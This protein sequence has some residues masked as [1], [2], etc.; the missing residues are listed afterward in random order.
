MLF[1]P[2][3][4]QVS[5]GATPGSNES[6]ISGSTAKTASSVTPSEIA[7]TNIVEKKKKKRRKSKPQHSVDDEISP[8]R[9]KKERSKKKLSTTSRASTN[10]TVDEPTS[11]TC[12][13]PSVWKSLKFRRKT[14]AGSLHKPIC[15]TGVDGFVAAWIVSELLVRGYK[16]RGTVQNKNDDI[17]RLYELPHA[18]KNLTIVETSLL[19]AQSCDM[20]VDGCDFVIHSGTPT[21]CSVRDPYSEQ[22]VTSLK[23]HTLPR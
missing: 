14:T 10:R 15:V 18:K 8:P 20:A 12:L 19:T 2:Q 5:P 3:V 23:H 11:W 6:N 21:S 16:V 1:G 4:P 9:L 7:S 13:Y 22:Q 17:S